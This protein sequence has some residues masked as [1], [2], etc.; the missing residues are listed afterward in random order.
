[1]HPLRMPLAPRTYIYIERERERE[2]DIVVVIIIIIIPV[3]LLT[4]VVTTA[5]HTPGAGRGRRAGRGVRAQRGNSFLMVWY[6]GGGGKDR[7][8]T[9]RYSITSAPGPPLDPSPC[10][11][12]TAAPCPAGLGAQREKLFLRANKTN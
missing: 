2:G 8:S 1:M 3:V 11:G 9:D 12:H 5:I 6:R 10:P 4:I 7:H